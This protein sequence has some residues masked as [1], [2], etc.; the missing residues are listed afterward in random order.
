MKLSKNTINK[1]FEQINQ[2]HEKIHERAI[3]LFPIGSNVRV[4]FNN[5]GRTLKIIN[6]IN[7]GR[8]HSVRVLNTK[9][10]KEYVLDLWWLLRD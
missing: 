8:D 6:H 5:G 3:K 1:L 9:T 7:H 4:Y 2:V 10:N